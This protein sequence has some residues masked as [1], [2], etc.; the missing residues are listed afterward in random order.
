MSLEEERREEL[1]LDDDDLLEWD[2]LEC[3]L[4][5]LFGMSRI[6]KARPVVGSTV[7]STDGLCATWYPS[8][9]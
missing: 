5:E 7:E 1:F 9:M 8:M 6:F 2:L 4:L 3:D